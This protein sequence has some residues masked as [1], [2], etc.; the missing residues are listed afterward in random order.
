MERISKVEY[1]IIHHSQRDLDFP[2]FI[3]LRHRHL[4][5][6]EEIGYHFLIGNGSL[7]TEDGKLYIGRP[8]HLVGAHALGYNRASLGIC[9]IG[10]L[11]IT[12]PTERQLETLTRL[13]R[14]KMKQYRIPSDNIRGHGGL[15][16]I[17]KSCPGRNLDI[18]Y[19]KNGL[20]EPSETSS[21][22]QLVI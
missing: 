9:L 7:F 19:I 3:R 5:G 20:Y 1:I 15:P 6:W 11:D 17:R 13:L 12:K 10:N 21:G 2:A 22:Q 16:N 18:N 14:E 4:R 8:E